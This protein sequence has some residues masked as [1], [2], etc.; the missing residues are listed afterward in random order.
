MK[1]RIV[2]KKDDPRKMWREIKKFL[3]NEGTAQN[4]IVCNGTRYTDPKE[5]A[6][7]LNRFFLSIVLARLKA[8]CASCAL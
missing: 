7:T 4:E 8:L 5:A 6:D 1:N 3:S 2:S